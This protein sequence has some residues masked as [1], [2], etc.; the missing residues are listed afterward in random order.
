LP[1]GTRLRFFSD[2]QEAEAWLLEGGDI[3]R[4]A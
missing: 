2:I 1:N 3:A 4:R